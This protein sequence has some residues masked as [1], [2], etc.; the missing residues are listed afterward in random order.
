MD[1]THAVSKADF[2]FSPVMHCVFILLWR[3]ASFLSFKNECITSTAP[4]MYTNE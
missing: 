1:E 4:F 3:F 2:L